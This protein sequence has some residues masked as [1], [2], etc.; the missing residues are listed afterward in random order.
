MNHNYGIN[1]DK[2]LS[3]KFN[4]QPYNVPILFIA[5]VRRRKQMCT[6]DKHMHVQAW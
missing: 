3:F 2:L 6:K 5:Y 1:Y 4:T